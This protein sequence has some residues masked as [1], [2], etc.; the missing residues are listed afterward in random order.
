MCTPDMVWR[1]KQELSHEKRCLLDNAA[2]GRGPAFEPLGPKHPRIFN[3]HSTTQQTKPYVPAPAPYT[4]P[5]PVRPV[6]K[7]RPE[8]TP[9]QNV[10][11]LVRES[12]YSAPAP[13]GYGSARAEP[14]GPSEWLKARNLE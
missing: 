1:P 10:P 12:T 2:D 9:S 14:L 4:P 11:N 13:R 6:Y 8:R 5:R 3:T 7:P